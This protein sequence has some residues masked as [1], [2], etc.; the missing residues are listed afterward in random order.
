MPVGLY[1]LELERAFL[2]RNGRLT[3]VQDDPCAATDMHAW[4]QGIG[5]TWASLL[6]PNIPAIIVVMLASG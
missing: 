3:F 6:I 2:K 5:V 4:M 1:N